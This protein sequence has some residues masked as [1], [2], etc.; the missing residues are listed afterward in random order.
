MLSTVTGEVDV[1]GVK[2][3]VVVDPVWSYAAIVQA[4]RLTGYEQG[5]FQ[6]AMFAISMHKEIG[7]SPAEVFVEAGKHFDKKARKAGNKIKITK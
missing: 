7:T 1:T 2:T 3:P 5:T 6:E 4:Q